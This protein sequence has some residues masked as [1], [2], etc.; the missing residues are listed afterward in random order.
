MGHI[1][2]KEIVRNQLPY[3]VFP[4]NIQGLHAKETGEKGFMLVQCVNGQLKPPE[5]IVSDALRWHQVPLDI[6]GIDSLDALYDQ[7]N[8]QM[9]Q[10][11]GSVQNR[12]SVIRVVLTGQGIIHN[13][14]ISAKE[15][16]LTALRDQLN[17]NHP[18]TWLEKVVIDTLSQQTMEDL[19]K[20]A[21]PIAS[22]VDYLENCS[23]DNDVT[24]VF[25]EVLDDLKSKLPSDLIRPGEH[26][27]LAAKLDT[28]STLAKAQNLVIAKLLKGVSI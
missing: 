12:L 3:I 28:A 9:K 24:T 11:V 27:D 6:T 21:G 1:H 7:F 26:L 18:N 10:A 4:G 14:I 17:W 25:K 5:F 22:F 23:A 16:V 2:K 20:S 13:A 19:R 8:Q 15:E